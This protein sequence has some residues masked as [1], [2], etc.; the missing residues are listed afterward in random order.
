MLALQ[1]TTTFSSTLKS[2]WPHLD[3]KT[4]MNRVDLLKKNPNQ[5]TQAGLPCC[6]E[7][8]FFHHVLQRRPVVFDTMAKLL[9][10]TGIGF[11][12]DLVIR[13]DEDLL[14]ADYAQS[15]LDN[16]AGD[17]PEQADWMVLSALCD[18]TNIF[19][20]EGT[21][22]ELVAGASGGLP[23][24]V[25]DWYQKSK[26]YK[27]V[28]LEISVPFTSP[29]E[30]LVKVVKTANNHI[31]LLIRM[32]MLKSLMSSSPSS[33]TLHYITVEKAFTFDTTLKTITFDLWTWGESL[34]KQSKGIKDG[35]V[36]GF[37]LSFSDF[38]S[39]YLGAIIA[40]F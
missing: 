27:S 33:A 19:D 5:I 12:G 7:A 10:K 9:F 39:N 13:P 23:T 1:S 25:R 40:E 32:P 30:D 3:E 21:P 28:E 11:I 15:V 18:T 17:L 6:A 22:G 36:G 37:T 26:L 4:V 14:E 31:T 38:Q 29:D 34:Q 35:F 16:D 20:F 2:S 8:A 24:T